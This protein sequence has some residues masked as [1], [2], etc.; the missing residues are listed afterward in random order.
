MSKSV[1]VTG[2][3]GFIGKNLVVALRRRQDVEI[4]PF[5]V[6]NSLDELPHLAARADI[7][8]HLAG[9]NRPSNAHE[10][11]TG[12][13]DLTQQLCAALV[14]SGRATPLILCSSV[15][16]ALD[17]PY[18]VSKKAAE[19]AAFA[20]AQAHDA[21]VHV[22]RLP[23]AFGKWCR[24]NY[25]SV[26]ATF[27]HN[28]ARG[29]PIQVND[30]DRTLELV[31]VDDIVRAFLAILDGQVPRKD[32]VYAC[33]DPVH[34]IS[35][36][37]L[38]TL[39]R[40]FAESRSTLI[41]PDMSDA[42][43]RK[44]YATYVSYL[45]EDSFSFALERREDARGSLAEILKSPHTGQL[46][47]STTKPGVTRGNHYHDSKIEK[48]IVLSGDAVIRFE[49]I[50]SGKRIDVPVSGAD[51]RVVD[52]PPG[53]SHHIQN[54]GSSELVVLFWANELFNRDAPDTYA[55]EVSR[56]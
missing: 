1:L 50:L 18:G 47:F 33:V 11:T 32:G 44:M 21:P 16:A 51:M 28:I 29:L 4:L 31:Y 27:C 10:F 3:N 52:I 20:Y 34:R 30:P 15:Q 24:P 13:A 40:S 56:G 6:E 42:L 38:E 48:F 14:S 5:D 46:F 25:N 7:V 41:V 22:F 54:V 35:L 19:E 53:Y 9:V 36:S 2:A 39:L 12:N 49:H 37:A 43:T 17:N 45:P 8:F 23:N 55:H 26:V